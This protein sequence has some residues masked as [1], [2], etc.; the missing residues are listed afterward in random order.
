MN[1]GIAVT[2]THQGDAR[3]R[4]TPT[5]RS[6]TTPTPSR[7]SR[8]AAPVF[9]ARCASRPASTAAR[10]LYN[11]VRSP[12]SRRLG[13]GPLR[14]HRLRLLPGRGLADPRRRLRAAALEAEGGKC[15]STTTRHRRQR[16]AHR[17]GQHHH[18]R[19][20][21]VGHC[22][23]ALPDRH[24]GGGGPLKPQG[25]VAFTVDGVPR[26]TPRHRRQ[27]DAEPVGRRCRCPQGQGDVH[28]DRA[29]FNA[30]LRRQTVV[31]VKATTT[32]PVPRPRPSWSRSSRPPTPGR[33]AGQGHDRPQGD[34][35]EEG[36]RQDRGQAR[37][38]EGRR[39]QAQERQGRSQAQGPEEGQEQAQGDYAG[40]RPSSAPS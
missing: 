37:H 36:H 35:G 31:N 15:G 32:V 1:G 16:P 6:R 21:H 33:R 3:S 19:G 39:R 28:P 12:T 7:R 24:V 8:W 10:A 5:R 13:P 27:G 9:S 23:R 17:Q 4:S 40:D 20:R 14:S 34:R 2:S 29:A 38:Q 22:R 30:R 18:H 11:V 26:A 25:T